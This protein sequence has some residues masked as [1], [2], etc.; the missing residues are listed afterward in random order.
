M[1]K[2]ERKEATLEEEGGKRGKELFKV[3]RSSADTTI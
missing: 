1:E 3:L 2:M